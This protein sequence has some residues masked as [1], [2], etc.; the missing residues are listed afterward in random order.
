MGRSSGC[1]P[2]HQSS[3]LESNRDKSHTEE[4][5]PSRTFVK[6]DARITR[7]LAS[8]EVYIYAMLSSRSVE[9]SIGHKELL[10]TVSKSLILLKKQLEHLVRGNGFKSWT[11]LLC[12]IRHGGHMQS[13]RSWRLHC[14]RTR[15]FLGGRWWM[16]VNQRHTNKY[17]SETNALRRESVV[18]LLVAKPV[19]RSS[20]ATLVPVIG[21]CV[22]VQRSA[23]AKIGSEFGQQ[24]G[25]LIRSIVEFTD[26][27]HL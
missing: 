7:T 16:N 17:N 18:L 27:A 15:P 26:G 1:T 6:H 4:A 2:Q 21:W 20:V 11:R 10:E 5:R 24:I 9:M 25:K 12:S 13:T 23:G 14:R 22:D 19:E 8:E 3:F